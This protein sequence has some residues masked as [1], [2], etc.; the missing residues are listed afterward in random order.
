[1]EHS[2][3]VVSNQKEDSIVHKGLN[4]SEKASGFIDTDIKKPDSLHQGRELKSAKLNVFRIIP[5][6]NI[7]RLTKMLN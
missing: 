3:S 5:K 6:F 2:K 1:M 7:L 4:V